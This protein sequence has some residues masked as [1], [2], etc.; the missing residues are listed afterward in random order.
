M[1]GSFVYINIGMDQERE[2]GLSQKK[3]E[4]SILRHQG[5]GAL[6]P[7]LWYPHIFDRAL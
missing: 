5:Y 4:L 3:K 6:A 1:I 2:I 7:R